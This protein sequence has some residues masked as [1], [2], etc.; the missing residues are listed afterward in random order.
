[1]PVRYEIHGIAHCRT[2][3]MVHF[4]QFL[5]LMANPETATDF[6]D[7]VVAIHFINSDGSDDANVTGVYGCP[8]GIIPLFVSADVNEFGG[9]SMLHGVSKHGAPWDS[10]GQASG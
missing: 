4:K 3:A 10:E 1:M 5:E 7:L 2:P 6:E 9:F 8:D